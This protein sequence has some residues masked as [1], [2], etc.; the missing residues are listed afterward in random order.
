MGPLILAIAGLLLTASNPMPE[1]AEASHP[2]EP[3]VDIDN[4]LKKVLELNQ[5][6]E[7]QQAIDLLLKAVENQKED[8]L[9]RT[10]LVQTFDLF[11]SDEIERGQERIKNNRHDQNAYLSVAGALELLGDNFRAM[12]ILLNGIAHK[13]SPEL[14]MRVA[15][16]ELKAGRNLE[17]LDVFLEVTRI[18]NKNSLAHNNAAFILAETSAKDDQG[19]KQAEKLA[20]RALKLEPKNPQYFDT[21]AEVYFRKGERNTAENLIKEAIKLAPD[22][23]QL[24]NRLEIIENGPSELFIAK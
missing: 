4:L 8:S 6:K 11:L 10:L 17:A 24:K 18:D 21:L 13:P 19:M 2:L 14:W 16:L 20:K 22:D 23:E 5:K 7:H 15:G 12:E 9:I 3:I 1:Q